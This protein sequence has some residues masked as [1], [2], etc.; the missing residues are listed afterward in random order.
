MST[1]SLDVVPLTMLLMVSVSV[2]SLET[3]GR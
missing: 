2:S 1:I 3:M